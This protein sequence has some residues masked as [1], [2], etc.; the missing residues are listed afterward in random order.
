VPLEAAAVA[1]YR[2]NSAAGDSVVHSVGERAAGY[3]LRLSEGVA[4]GGRRCCAVPGSPLKCDDHAALD[5]LRAEGR[6]EQERAKQ[7]RCQDGKEAPPGGHRPG[8]GGQGTG[9]G[10]VRNRVAGFA[11]LLAVSSMD[12]NRG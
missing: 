3:G 8:R 9:A 7:Q 12:R 1:L 4:F 10:L 5:M 6:P 2:G 11:V